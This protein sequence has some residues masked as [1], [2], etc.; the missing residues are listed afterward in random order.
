MPSSEENFPRR[1]APPTDSSYR[2]KRDKRRCNSRR[3]QNIYFSLSP[4]PQKKKTRTISQ[5]ARSLEWHHVLTLHIMVEK[6]CITF[7]LFYCEGML[8]LAVL[9]LYGCHTGGFVT[10]SQSPERGSSVKYSTAESPGYVS[11][12]HCLTPYKLGGNK[13]EN[14]CALFCLFCTANG[15]AVAV[16]RPLRY[17]G[18]DC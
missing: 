8:S 12:A 17:N 6:I 15:W 13:S 4:P 2:Q 3:T 5:W 14:R 1:Y 18:L 7:F 10:Q 16:P 11:W 9:W